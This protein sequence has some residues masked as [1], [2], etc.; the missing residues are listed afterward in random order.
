MEM[1]RTTPAQLVWAITV[2]NA[3]NRITITTRMP[4]T[5]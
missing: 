5:P 4:L 2:I 1:G 3:W